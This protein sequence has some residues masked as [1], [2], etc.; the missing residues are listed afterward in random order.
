MRSAPEVFRLSLSK[1][2]RG[3]KGTEKKKKKEIIKTKF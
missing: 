2:T 3:E 1:S